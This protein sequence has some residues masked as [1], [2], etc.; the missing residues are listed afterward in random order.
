MTGPAHR[1]IGH[2]LL[3]PVVLVVSGAAA[4][5]DELLPAEEAFPCIAYA[6]GDSVVLS[7]QLPEG[8]Y[9]YRH[10]FGFESLTDGIVL[11]PP[12]LPDGRAHVD[13]FF[14]A[15]EIYR[16]DF[17]IRIPYRNP[18]GAGELQIRLD[19]QGCA[20]IGYCYLPMS[21]DR[22]VRLPGDE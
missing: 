15:V 17:E 8:Y 12:E 16:G 1:A 6:E 10:R 9:L 19:L 22:R 3:L 13:E 18:D 7:F 21:W 14:G 2:K 11:E 4:Q 20:D 5:F